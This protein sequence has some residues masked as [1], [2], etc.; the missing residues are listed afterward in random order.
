M[1]YLEKKKIYGLLN[2]RKKN[3]RL[4]I[5]LAGLI[6]LTSVSWYLGRSKGRATFDKFIFTLGENRVITTVKLTNDNQVNLLEYLGGIWEVNGRHQVDESMRDVFFAVLSTVQVHRPVSDLQKDSIATFLEMKG[7]KIEISNN[8]VP[9]VSYL[10][11][12]NKEK[13]LT[14]FMF[15]EERIPYQMQIPGYLS[16][17]S[18]I[19]EVSE[20]DWRERYI[21]SMD[22]SRL[23]T[24]SIEAENM[25]PLVFEY[26]NNFI[27]VQG[28]EKMDTVRV[29]DFL[30]YAANLQANTF[31]NESDYLDI[32]DEPFVRIRVT[33]IAN[34]NYS[35]DLYKINNDDQQVLGILNGDE[36]AL[37]QLKSIE[38]LL[39]IKDDFKSL[40]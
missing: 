1:A 33:E 23:K 5:T 2:Q 38:Y 6:I 4:L 7:T 10:V 19:Y 26:K 27:G 35:L 30:Q 18:G 40:D 28:V 17:I 37:F 9:V 8:G 21:W 24:F 14:Y 3:I 32:S 11:G 29:M 15:E 22:W 31:L 36:R 13:F 34:R 39:K 12:G 25:D 16:Y 20:S